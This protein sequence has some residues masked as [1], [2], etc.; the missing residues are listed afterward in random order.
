MLKRGTRNLA[1]KEKARRL[2]R[3]ASGSEKL[4]RA[5]L[6]RG[7]LGYNFRFQFPISQYVLD[8]Y[9]PAAMLCI[10]VDGE[11]HDPIADARRDVYLASIGILT[12]RIPSTHLWDDQGMD[13][14]LAR[15]HELCEERAPRKDDGPNP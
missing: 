11:Q 5:K 8:F 2:R 4:L 15:I 6:R 9:C 14:H 7:N 12:Y 10:E 13:H 3:E 1:A